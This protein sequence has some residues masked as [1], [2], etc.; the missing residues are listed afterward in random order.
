M[1]GQVVSCHPLVW[2]YSQL[3]MSERG[4]WDATQ[5]ERQRNEHSQAEGDG[6]NV[7]EPRVVVIAFVWR[8]RKGMSGVRE[9]AA[10]A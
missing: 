5:V 8:G 9:R 4:I 3:A 10:R 1:H 7:C 2:L 6:K